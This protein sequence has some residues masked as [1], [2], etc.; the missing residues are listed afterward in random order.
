MKRV[1]SLAMV[2][3]LSCV[4]LT[5]WT[6]EA[7]SD[8]VYQDLGLLPGL[9]SAEAWNISGHLVVGRCFTTGSQDYEGFIWTPASGI[10]PLGTAGGTYSRAYGVNRLGDSVGFSQTAD[11]LELAFFKTKR[12]AMKALPYLP[13]PNPYARGYAINSLRQ[14]VG[15]SNNEFSNYKACIWWD[16]DSTDPP[17]NLGNLTGEPEH[18]SIA[19]CINDY[20]QVVGDSIGTNG[21][22]R[23]MYW[24]P[25]NGMRDLGTLGGGSGLARGINNGGAVVGSA[26][27]LDGLR[28]GFIIRPNAASPRMRG[29]GGLGGSGE[30]SGFA[31][32]SY[33]QGINGRGEV[34]GFAY[35]ADNEQVAFLWTREGGIQNLNTLVQDL[36]EGVVLSR[37][38]AINAHGD[39][40]GFTAAGQAFFLY[41]EPL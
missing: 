6:R 33:A 29:L 38:C 11:A 41:P 16:P 27:N 37:A 28:E 21:L 7:A 1:K 31:T 12:G 13:S 34:V 2:L 24:D 8:Y 19:F 5:A 22:D 35:N 3:L 15:F 14:I 23:P 26:D 25:A 30:F 20:T 17:Q 40:V 9:S 32:L 18:N 4:L 10:H 39:I 36:P